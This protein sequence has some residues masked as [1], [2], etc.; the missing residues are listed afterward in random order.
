MPNTEVRHEWL[1]E[2]IAL[3][4]SFFPVVKGII[5]LPSQRVCE[6]EYKSLLFFISFFLQS[7]STIFQALESCY[8]PIPTPK[9][10]R[11]PLRVLEGIAT[12]ESVG[13]EWDIF[14]DIEGHEEPIVFFSKDGVSASL[15]ARNITQATVL[16]A[17]R[18]SL[19]VMK[20]TRVILL[21]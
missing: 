17:L 13:A 10:N 11:I 18:D 16:E 19:E 3:N 2:S 12:I 20:M 4:M 1:Y 6:E 15:R 7:I 9:K 5:H 8:M 21:H 14:E